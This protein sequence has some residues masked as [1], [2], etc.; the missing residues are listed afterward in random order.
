MS[1]AGIYT[2]NI[3]PNIYYVYYNLSIIKKLIAV[4][5]TFFIFQ[6]QK[7]QFRHFLNFKLL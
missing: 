4:N 6:N 1:D 2:H 7:K 5:D 3:Y